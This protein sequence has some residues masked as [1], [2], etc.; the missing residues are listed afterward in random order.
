MSRADT[1]IQNF[2]KI[3]RKDPY[4]LSLVNSMGLQLDDIDAIAQKIFL[5]LFFD[6]MD[7]DYGIPAMAKTLQVTFPA[8]ATTEEKR[9]ILQAKWKSKGKCSE[10][11]LQSIADSW[12]NGEVTVKFENSII[13]ITFASLAGVPD[14]IDNL[15]E[16]IER[17]KPAYL[18][19]E[20]I[21]NW[22]YW[23]LR[24][25]WNLSWDYWDSKNINWDN[26]E[27]TIVK[28]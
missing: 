7:E 24:D 27:K 25:S 11:L 8:G 12:K 19:A 4:I 20:Y 26:L 9:S 21:F 6:T 14:N 23:D 10:E 5:N 1:L 22:L 18:L 2:N 17:V 16:A 15:K 28:P 3:F 13:K